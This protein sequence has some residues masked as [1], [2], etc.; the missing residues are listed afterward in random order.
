MWSRV[1]PIIIIV[2]FFL[3][4]AM[5]GIVERNVWKSIFYLCSAILN[6]AA[7]MM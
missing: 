2:L 6:I 5:E 3:A 1:F 4:S 7:M